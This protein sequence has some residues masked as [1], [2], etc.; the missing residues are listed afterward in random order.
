M[1]SPAIFIQTQNTHASLHI[2]SMAVCRSH[3][4]ETQLLPSN[5]ALLWIFASTQTDLSRLYCC[6][7][8]SIQQGKIMTDISSPCWVFLCK[9]VAWAI[10]FEQ[11]HMN[12]CGPC[13]TSP[14]RPW[15]SSCRDG[16]SGAF[17][18]RYQSVNAS[19]FMFDQ[20]T[21]IFVF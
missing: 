10:I 2:D 9:G 13:W 8:W 6:R 17:V 20:F 3:L 16:C 11:C 4:G 7:L 19:F 14:V 12:V 15:P 1:L 21:Y 5:Y 18:W